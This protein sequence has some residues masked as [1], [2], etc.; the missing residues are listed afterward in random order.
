[1]FAA[2]KGTV[3]KRPLGGSGGE[4]SWIWVPESTDPSKMSSQMKPKLPVWI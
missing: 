1:M 2:G 3:Q 4:K